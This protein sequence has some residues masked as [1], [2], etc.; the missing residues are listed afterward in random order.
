MEAYRLVKMVFPRGRSS[1]WGFHPIQE[2]H[3]LFWNAFSQNKKKKESLLKQAK[4]CYVHF[5]PHSVVSGEGSV[6][7]K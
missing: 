7:K 6:G 4:A 2:R 5:L 1:D 3:I